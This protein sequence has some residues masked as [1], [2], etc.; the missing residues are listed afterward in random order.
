MS[1]I[2]ILG[3]VY[4]EH[5]SLHNYKVHT[6]SFINKAEEDAFLF[7]L[8]EMDAWRDGADG[9]KGFHIVGQAPFYTIDDLKKE[10]EC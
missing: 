10:F 1:E 2:R 4:G 3:I 8:N 9:E 5:P 6:Y 7:G